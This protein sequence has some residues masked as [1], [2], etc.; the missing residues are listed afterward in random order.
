MTGDDENLIFVK[1]FVA[2][3]CSA[4]PHDGGFRRPRLS[5]FEPWSDP[6][7]LFFCRQQKSMVSPQPSKML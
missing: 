7:A 1:K 4:A 3:G 6:S 2:G 5:L